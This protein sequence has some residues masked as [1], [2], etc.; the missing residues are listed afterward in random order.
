KCAPVPLEIENQEPVTQVLSVDVDT[1]SVHTVPAEFKSQTTQTETLQ[2]RAE[3]ECESE[4]KHTS[5][6]QERSEKISEDREKKATA[7]PRKEN[8]SHVNSKTKDH[9]SMFNTIAAVTLC[10]GLSF[11]AYRKYIA[12]ELN[13]KLVGVW[14]GIVGALA[15]TNFNLTKH[16][17]F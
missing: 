14:T 6:K 7:P 8:I 9:V 15:I 5:V 11:G 12:G 1:S 4:E 2:N 17:E 13:W 3:D 10:S 16:V